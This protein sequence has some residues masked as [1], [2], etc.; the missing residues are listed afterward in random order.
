[1]DQLGVTSVL[2]QEHVVDGQHLR[3]RLQEEFALALDAALEFLGHGRRLG[4]R[5]V[6]LH[7]IFLAHLFG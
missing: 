7:L 1:M 4:C 6:L 3:E 2:C 5:T